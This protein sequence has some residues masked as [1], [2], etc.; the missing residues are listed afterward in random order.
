MVGS[1]S[2]LSSAFTVLVPPR[3]VDTATWFRR[4]YFTQDGRAFDEFS[5]PWV[6]A[7]QG[8]CWAADNPQY[9][10]IWL[11]WAARMFKTQFAQGLQ[12]KFADVDPCSMMFATVDET[13][14]KQ[15]FGRYWKM[16]AHCP[17]LRDQLPIER[18]RSKTLIKLRQ[19]EI[20]GAWARGKSRLADKSIRVGH[21]NEIDKWE[22]LS[23]STEGDPLPRFLK[24][25]DEYP[26]ATFV[27][28]ST[29]S[30]KGSSRVEQGRLR[31]TNH[32]FYVPCPHC[33][34]YQVVRFGNGT[35]PGGIFWEKRTDGKS[36][37][38][39]AL[40]TA[41]YVCQHCEGHIADINRLN[42]M[43]LGVWVPE[44]CSVDHDRAMRA[45]E[46]PVDDTSWLTGEPLR[47][48]QD[49]G[50][51]ISV[52]CALFHGWGECAY[53]FLTMRDN[54]TTLRQY[55]NEDLGETWE[56]VQRQQTWETLGQSII[57]HDLGCSVVP[58]GYGLVTCGI[59]KQLGYYVY[60][61]NAWGPDRQCHTLDYGEC[62]NND[63]VIR[64]LTRRYKIKNSN[65]TLPIAITLVDA[66][67]KPKD[68]AELVKQCKRQRIKIKPC[69]GS[70]ISLN[71]TYKVTRQ[72]TD[73]AMPGLELVHVDTLTTQD[74]VEDQIKN[75]AGERSLSL[76]AG[77]LEEHQDYLQQILND[78]EVEKL[79]AKN[80]LAIVWQRIDPDIPND[81]RDC[82]RYSYVAMMME[83][84][85]RKI[86]SGRQRSHRRKSTKR[87]S[88]ID[89]LTRQGGWIQ[90]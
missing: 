80:N 72:G 7:P 75:A 22:H 28:E 13:N 23:T 63:D 29:P 27:L 12:M 47:N 82:K 78:G 67:Y 65:D 64:V 90:R 14:C 57:R 87:T 31:S 52:L 36:D 89:A 66:G 79:D 62:D 88:R 41:Y 81:V 15:V 33:G 11:Q 25:G 16:L 38:D 18:Y 86:R 35:D 53:R 60:E 40:K 83:T 34:K 49:Y 74:W 50:S 8:P 70:N 54:R 21:A 6:T 19:C 76:F 45:R 32:S 3:R 20:Y 10:R 73:S 4:N 68:V 9:R 58:D 37:R 56:V 24:R 26:D 46:L 85:G 69:K 17:R 44:G 39:L 51:H 55:I 77:S 2:V 30:V 59:D 61:V 1:V 71:A 42:M 84:R 48:S 5:V 43:A